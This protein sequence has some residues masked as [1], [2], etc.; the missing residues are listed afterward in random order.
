MLYFSNVGANPDE[1]DLDQLARL[2]SFKEL[3]YPNAL[4]ESYKSAIQFR[5]RFA[6]QLE[7]KVRDLQKIDDSTQPPPLSLVFRTS[8]SS[9]EGH[10]NRSVDLPQVIDFESALKADAEK[11]R[12]RILDAVEVS[13]NAA[14]GVRVPLAIRNT[15]SSGIRNLY[16]QMII[17]PTSDSVA[18]VT[19]EEADR[20]AGSVFREW[21]V[22]LRDYTWHTTTSAAEF[23]DG[24][25]VA[26]TGNGWE[27]TFEWGALQPQRIRLV[28]PTLIIR[29]KAD[30]QVEFAA[31]VFADSL[32]EPIVLKTILNITVRSKPIALADLVPN[33]KALRKLPEETTV[34]RTRVAH[35]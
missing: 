34:V 26:K 7:F 32:P 8:D 24:E 13:I 15:G 19:Q 35:E 12:Q 4:T 21:L 18:V 11:V 9:F 27:F 1:I 10:I 20:E 28:K 5:D 30:S 22:N 17:R 25:N 29:A 6:K 3:T 31:K 14:V 16:V 2:K 33:L 23:E